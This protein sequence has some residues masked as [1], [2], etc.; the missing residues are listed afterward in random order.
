MMIGKLIYLPLL[1]LFTQAIIPAF[2]STE[3]K[4]RGTLIEAGCQISSESEA[5]EISF[6]ALSPAWFSQHPRSEPRQ[7]N[8]LLTNCTPESG[9]TVFITFENQSDPDFPDLF[10][11]TGE[12]SG[13][14][15]ALET[16]GGSPLR[17]GEKRTLGTITAE[18]QEF[19]FNAFIQRLTA[20]DITPGNFTS[21]VNFLV[22]YD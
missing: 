13:I 1:Y 3:V 8:V 5:Q 7:F 22:E 11:V 6:P 10:S 12:A 20:T 14:A 15:I 17:N 21:L 19:S 4:F 2:S 16:A 9:T 18:E